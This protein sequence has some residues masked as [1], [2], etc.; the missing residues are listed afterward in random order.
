MPIPMT[1]TTK[2]ANRSHAASFALAG[3]ILLCMAAGAW[4]Q[5]DLTEAELNFFNSETYRE[6]LWIALQRA[7]NELRDP[8]CTETLTDADRLNIVVIEHLVTGEEDAFPLS[9]IWRD[10]LAVERCGVRHIHNLRFD[11]REQAA[12]K[13]MVLVPGQSMTSAQLQVDTMRPLVALVDSRRAN[14]QLCDDTQVRDTSAPMG[15]AGGEPD[16]TQ[17]WIETWTVRSCGDV[18]DVPITFKTNN[19]GSTTILPGRPEN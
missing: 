9:G 16:F 7:E 3:S 12:P 1:N 10:Q 18:M 2:V 14:A 8:S 15:L 11:A 6:I 17:G 4:A 5:D 19:D 13:P